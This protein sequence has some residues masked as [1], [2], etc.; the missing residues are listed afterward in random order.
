MTIGAIIAC[1]DCGARPYPELSLPRIVRADFDLH[2]E[3]DGLW[4]CSQ[5]RKAKAPRVCDPAP[6]NGKP[7]DQLEG[8]L[9]ELGR[10]IANF[11]VDIF[12]GPESDDVSGEVDEQQQTAALELVGRATWLIQQLKD[13]ASASRTPAL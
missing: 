1:F 3:S 11:D 6:A 10:L 4:R 9:G 13:A 5:H 8:A 7:L 12:E 2:K